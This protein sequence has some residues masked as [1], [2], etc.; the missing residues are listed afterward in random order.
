MRSIFA[1]TFYW[2]ALLNPRDD[3]HA[4]V[5]NYSRQLKSA[6][7]VTSDEVI[8]EF[9]NFF[10]NYH[11]LMRQ[12][13]VHRAKEILNHD[14]IQVIPSNRDRFLAGIE[15][16]QQRPD[17][18]YSLTDCLSMLIMRELEIQEILTH[19]K[20]FTQEGFMILLP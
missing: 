16:Y 19:D 15:L 14:A 2:T 1:D 18:G 11:P 10:S 6:I 4:I 12:G 3:Y 7:L 5:K 8:T 20:H 13:A 9:L 17:K